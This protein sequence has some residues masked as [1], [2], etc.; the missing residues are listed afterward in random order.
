MPKQRLK[1][2][3]GDVVLFTEQKKNYS[4][5]LIVRTTYITTIEALEYTEGR[6]RHNPYRLRGFN[7]SYGRK[8]LQLATPEQTLR[9]KLGGT[10]YAI[11]LS[12]L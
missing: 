1:Y 12:Q 10:N 3:V 4:T 5:S 8:Q 2:K 7:S 11:P 9:F 6:S